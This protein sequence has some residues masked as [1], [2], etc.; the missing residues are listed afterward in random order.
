M[1]VDSVMYN[2]SRLSACTM[3]S[4]AVLPTTLSWSYPYADGVPGYLPSQKQSG[5][6][7]QTQATSRHGSSEKYAGKL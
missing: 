6:S 4:A 2:Y 5:G 1:N 3:S 7:L